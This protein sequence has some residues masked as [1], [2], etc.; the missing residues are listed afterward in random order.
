M[1]KFILFFIIIILT[2]QIAFSKEIS[3]KITPIQTISTTHDELEIGDN[4]KFK[5]ID[6]IFVNGNIAIKKDTVILGEI[7]EVTP[8]GWVYDNAQ[9]KFKKFIIRNSN[10]N[11][12][13]YHSDLTLNSLD[14]LKNLKSKTRK[15]FEYTGIAFRG[16]EL[17]LIPLNYKNLIFNIW[18]NY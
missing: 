7:D 16:K 3:L 10:G 11:L 14:L 15:I 2:S 4:I 6:D 5:V 12:Q 17:N 8:N 9:I 13:L 1:K 18:I